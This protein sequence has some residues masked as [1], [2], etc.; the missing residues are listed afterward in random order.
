M[1]AMVRPSG[2][3]AVRR[4]CVFL[5]APLF[6]AGVVVSFLGGE[7]IHVFNG[8]DLLGLILMSAGVLGFTSELDK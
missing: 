3:V 6:L 1:G 2:R 4:R 5:W 8:V 7:M